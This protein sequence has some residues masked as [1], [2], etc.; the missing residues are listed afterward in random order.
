MDRNRRSRPHRRSLYRA[1]DTRWRVGAAS[2]L[3]VGSLVQPAAPAVGQEPSPSIGAAPSASAEALPE[4]IDQR[5]A[6]RIQEVIES[7]PRLRRLQPTAQAP[8]RV[9][10]SS[11][12]A[13]EMAALFAEDY[14]P[15]LVA[16]EDA[17]YTRLGL[18]SP[19]DDLGGLT[20]ELLGSQ[21]LAY[22]DPRTD[23]FT[24][25]G[26]IDE[27]GPLES[28]V[29]AHEYTHAL[30]DQH[31]DL[32]ATLDIDPSESDRILAR[33][34]LAEGDATAVMY[35]WASSELNV[36]QLI[37]VAGSALTRQDERLLRRMPPLLRR[38]LE[39]PYLDG[40]AF[41][42][43]LRG[44]GDWAA[45]DEAWMALPESTEQI[46]HPE[47]Y[48]GE[49]PVPVV[50]PDI[51]GLLGEGWVASLSQTLGEGQIGVWLAD[52][53]RGTDVL[54]VPLPLPKA[55]AA[56]GWGGDRLVSLDGP[57]GRWAIVWQ[58]AWDSR[59]DAR[60]FRSAALDA[61]KDLA[62]A[63]A[64]NGADVVGGLSSPMLVLVADSE[65]TLAQ[66]QSALGTAS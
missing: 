23:T 1:W 10:D 63:H 29:V 52:G 14:P 54:G 15:E 46:I 16:A 13:A 43:A 44:R 39:L 17:L 26:P 36:L 49:H 62:G 53:R 40:Y 65:E 19:D 35:D 3:L 31:Y 61:T 27:V 7:V 18:L 60:E 25:V 48:P 22:Y 28:I 6:R 5:A 47:K 32:D 20:L 38:Q 64:V 24:L 45:V 9:I 11:A 33:S 51:A 66:L 42:N 34:A 8:F 59:S 41:V 30:Q 4:G 12:L 56:A 50:L 58:T 57:D 2:I 37:S 55:A 21:V